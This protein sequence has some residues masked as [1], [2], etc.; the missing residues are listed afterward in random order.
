[1]KTIKSILVYFLFFALPFS[2]L[3]ASE[4]ILLKDACDKKMISLKIHGTK[5]D[6]NL[7]YNKRYYGECISIEVKNLTGNL[8]N[9]K[10]ETGRKLICDYDSIQNMMIT[11]QLLFALN[12]K[13]TATY[14]AYAMCIE[15]NDHAPDNRSTF[16]IGGIADNYLIQLAQFIE[17][18]NYQDIAGQNA[19]WVLTNKSDT[20]SIYSSDNAEKYNLKKF[21][22]QFNI[23]KADNKIVPVVEPKNTIFI[24]R[25]EY[26]ISGIIKW[27][28]KT[29]G[30]ASLFV[31]DEQGNPVTMIFD[32]RKFSEGEHFYDFKVVSCLMKKGE[33]YLVRVKIKDI[34]EEE[35]VCKAE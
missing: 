6:A 26:N 34:T 3:Y 11:K 2:A 21:V 28:M 1:M 16:K 12:G 25:D 5:I 23:T 13:G 14:N 20:S 24:E 10:L 9:L 27:T 31:Y 15:K 22:S 32:K 35:L 19:V 4:P 30:Y 7:P 8:L 29:A 18:N 17:K 33:K